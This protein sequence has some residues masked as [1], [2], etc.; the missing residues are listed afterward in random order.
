[1]VEVATA[2]IEQTKAWGIWVDVPPVLGL[3]AEIEGFE[4]FCPFESRLPGSFMYL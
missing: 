4:V 3:F 2:K 1:M